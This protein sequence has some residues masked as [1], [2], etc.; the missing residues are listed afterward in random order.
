MKTIRHPA[1]AYQR[2]LTLIELMVA[3]VIGLVV[4]LAVTSAVTF[5]EAT[6]RSTTSINDMSQSGSFVAY[7]IDRA[8]RSAGSGFTQSWDLGAFGCKLNARR[9][10]T[11]ILPRTTALPAPFAGFLGGAAGTANLRLT[12]VLIDKGATDAD[13][14]ILVVMGGNASAGDVPRPII[15]GGA[16]AEIVRL[17][18]TVQIKPNDIALVTEAS[19]EDC[20]VEQVSPTYTEIAANDLLTFGGTYYTPGVTTTLAT[21]AASGS[22]YLTLLGS[23]T[24]KNVQFQMIGVGPNRTLVSYDLLQSNGSDTTQVLADGVMRMHALY[25][26]DTNKDGNFDEWVKPGSPGYDSATMMTRDKARQVVAVRIGLVLRSALLEKEDVSAK[27]PA[28]FVGTPGEIAA[29]TL[30][31]DDKRYRYRVV[32]FTVPLRNILLLGAS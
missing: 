11:A 14:D 29:V 32:E 22:S 27:I 19:H 2:G 31:N 6:K 30:S 23:D 12:P 9:G 26:I 5:S 10:S 17:D 28:M 18:N 20:L 24:A 25:G 4:T 16:S 21:L 3:M 8:I 15:A 13:S 7:E 1:A